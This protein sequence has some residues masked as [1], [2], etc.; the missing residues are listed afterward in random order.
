M[1]H[2]VDVDRV[3]IGCRGRFQNV[4]AD[5]HLA[6]VLVGSAPSVEV[7][8]A[9]ADQWEYSIGEVAHGDDSHLFALDLHNGSAAAA[10]A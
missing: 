3:A 8:S 6:T 2:G 7:T 5:M 9:G 4:D 1:C 10:N